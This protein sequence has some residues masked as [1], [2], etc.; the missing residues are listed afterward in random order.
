[1]ATEDAP[2]IGL[3]QLPDDI[4]RSIFSLLEAHDLAALTATCRDFGTGDDPLPESAARCA[5]AATWGPHRVTRSW[6]VA[7]RLTEL[8]VT[9]PDGDADVAVDPSWTRIVQSPRTA[10][11]ETCCEV[12]A[13]RT[14]VWLNLSDGSALCGRR[15]M[16][17][18]GGNSHAL[19]R[20]ATTGEPLA[21]KLGTVVAH[22]GRGGHLEADVFS[23]A[24]SAMVLDP[25]LAVHLARLGVDPAVDRR[26][27]E[28]IKEHG[29]RTTKH[30]ISMLPPGI[31]AIWMNLTPDVH[32]VFY[33][34]YRE[35]TRAYHTL[36]R[37][38]DGQGENG[39]LPDASPDDAE[40]VQ[41]RAY[42]ELEIDD[43]QRIVDA[44]HV[45][46]NDQIVG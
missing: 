40:A 21:V 39:W 41:I 35:Q 29:E 4:L 14:N 28:T 19:E 31:A 15:Q 18:N 7:L 32:H 3:L 23:Y 38:R 22:L 12:C 24:L 17:G 27:S 10:P 44:M 6:I 45:P 33:T 26:T 43:L 2:S 13:L 25:A 1:M 16:H 36:Q 46:D 11:L 34:N 5:L 9:A 30:M 20:N 37:R 42:A 8:P